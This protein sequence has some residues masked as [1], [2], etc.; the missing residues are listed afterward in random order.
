MNIDD[1]F[2][3]KRDNLFVDDK[4]LM[5]CHNI[6]LNLLS[7]SPPPSTFPIKTTSKTYLMWLET[8]PSTSISVKEDRSNHK[9]CH[10]VHQKSGMTRFPWPNHFHSGTIR[11]PPSG[12]PHPST[13]LAKT[14]SCPILNPTIKMLNSS[15]S[16][17]L[18]EKE[19][20]ILVLGRGSVFLRCFLKESLHRPNSLLTT[21]S[22]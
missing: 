18:W 9:F 15:K 14:K 6:I 12:T 8:T 20:A 22:T 16:L 5:K 11:L 7:W 21:I 2:C 3:R 17:R 19:H 10:L 13:D 1:Y 4:F